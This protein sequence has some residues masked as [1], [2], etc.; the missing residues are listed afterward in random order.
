[1]VKKVILFFF[2]PLFAVC[3]MVVPDAWTVYG[4]LKGIDRGIIHG[5]S[6][7]VSGVDYEV[8]A[9]SGD[10]YALELI[11]EKYASVEKVPEWDRSVKTWNKMMGAFFLPIGILAVFLWTIALVAAIMDKRRIDYGKDMLYIPLIRAKVDLLKRHWGFLMTLWMAGGYYLFRYWT[12][13]M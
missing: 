1:M 7:Q 8:R 9:W 6:E 4:Q 3:S 10:V 5:A 13:G 2:S 11:G 12:I